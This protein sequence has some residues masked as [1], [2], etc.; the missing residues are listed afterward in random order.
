[1]AR[2]VRKEE[3]GI[4]RDYVNLPEPKNDAQQP[5]RGTAADETGETE[6]LHFFKEFTI[7]ITFCCGRTEEESFT[8]KNVYK[9]YSSAQVY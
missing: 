8:C 3:S 4:T 5:E 7:S 6:E 9:Y 2:F 1:M